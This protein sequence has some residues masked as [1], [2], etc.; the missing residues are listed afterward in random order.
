MINQ[1]MAIWNQ[2]VRINGANP[3][4]TLR[5]HPEQQCVHTSTTV[6]SGKMTGTGQAAQRRLGGT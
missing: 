3:R 5:L 2:T 1:S 6:L 4:L